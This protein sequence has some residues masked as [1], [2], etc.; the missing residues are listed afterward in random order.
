M[1]RLSLRRLSVSLVL[2]DRKMLKLFLISFFHC[3]LTD[4]SLMNRAGVLAPRHWALHSAYWTGLFNWLGNCAGDASFAYIFA[5]M[6]S[7]ALSTGGTPALTRTQNVEIAIAVLL[8]W[9]LMNCLKIQSIGW[10]NNIASFIQAATIISLVVIILVIAPK[11]NSAKR[12]VLQ[13]NNDT[14]FDQTYYVIILGLLFP[15]YGFAGYDGPGHLAEETK[16]SGKSASMGIIYTVFATGMFGFVLIVALLLAMQDIDDAIGE[17]SGNA[18]V[19]IILQCSGTRIASIFSWLLVVN[20]FFCGSCSVTV[21]S[22]IWFALCR[23]RATIFS[24]KLCAINSYFHSPINGIIC[25]F[26]LTSLLL[27]LPLHSET[28]ESAFLDVVSLSVISLQI[29]YGIPI[30]MKV[31]SII[32][33][34]NHGNISDKLSDGSFSLGFFSLPLG[35]VSCM[36]LFFTSLVL[37]MPTAYPI[38]TDTMNFASVGVTGIILFGILNWEF[39][40]KRIFVGPRRADND[41]VIREGN[42][43]LHSFINHL[44]LSFL[45]VKFSN[46]NSHLSSIPCCVSASNTLHE[47]HIH[48][49][50]FTRTW[51]FKD[52]ITPTFDT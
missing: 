11:L 20:I 9:S 7:S 16:R 44:H 5:Q 34:S 42:F 51:T 41:Y 21:T 22:R 14:G 24:E 39:N 50:M 36:W 31:L 47:I 28:G 52:F 23:D 6:I 27:L 4:L 32:W 26:F 17:E 48:F 15:L 3:S 25:L 12:T 29:S 43:I 45:S 37:M 1:Q 46:L 10:V 19:Q 2:S 30:F 38:A 18:A 33:P 13:Y 40:S 35:L 49:L 8:V